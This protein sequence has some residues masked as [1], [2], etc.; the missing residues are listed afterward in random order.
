MYASL[1][2]RTRLEKVGIAIDRLSVIKKSDLSD[3]I[4]H[5]FFQ[6][7]VVPILLKGCTTWKLTKRM[8]RKLDGNCTRML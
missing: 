3:K 4:K 1:L 7:M 6:A 8:E 5:S 2:L